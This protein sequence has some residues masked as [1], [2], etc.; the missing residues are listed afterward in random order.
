MT[1]DKGGQRPAFDHRTTAGVSRR[2]H[3]GLVIDDPLDIEQQT[4]WLLHKIN[5][6]RFLS[7]AANADG[8][9]IWLQVDHL[10]DWRRHV[11]LGAHKDQPLVSHHELT[12]VNVGQRLALNRVP[13]K[14]AYAVPKSMSERDADAVTSAYIF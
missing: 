13:T 5:V 1:L 8:I 2:V 6:A 4:S 10:G 14:A 12:G 9:R 11:F 7:F 3:S